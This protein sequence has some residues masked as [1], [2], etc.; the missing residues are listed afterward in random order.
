[1]ISACVASWRD[2]CSRQ[3]PICRT[4][5]RKFTCACCVYRTHKPFAAQRH[6]SLPSRSTYYI[7][8]RLNLTSSPESVAIE[9][10]LPS[11]RA[12]HGDNPAEQI[13]TWHRL[14]ELDRILSQ[15]PRQTYAVFVLHRQYGYSREEIGAKLGCRTQWSRN[16]SHK[17]W[18]IVV[19]AWT[20]QWNRPRHVTAEISTQYAEQ[21]AA[22]WFVE[23]DC[24]DVD[25][26]TR[27]RLDEWLRRSPER[28]RA[29]LELLPIWEQSRIDP[30][31]T[32]IWR[33]RSPMR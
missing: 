28:V 7:S 14:E 32:W 18:C 23:M 24:D 6:T 20:G 2:G 30:R 10:A 12:R 31:S 33:A 3:P 15:L 25:R 16:I 1:M 17:L 26:M 9:D 11:L 29:F 4:L 21:E 8:I 22:E 27:Q 13:E 19:C 5:C